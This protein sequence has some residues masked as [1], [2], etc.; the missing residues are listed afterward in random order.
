MVSPR[1]SKRG[2]DFV[3]LDVGLGPLPDPKYGG[4]GSITLSVNKKEVKSCRDA[5]CTRNNLCA[6][7]WQASSE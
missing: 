3:W 4:F 7:A 6:Y 2:L 1:N 5:I